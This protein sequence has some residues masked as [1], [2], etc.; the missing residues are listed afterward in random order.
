MCDDLDFIITKYLP[1]TIKMK[2]NVTILVYKMQTISNQNPNAL[3]K[4]INKYQAE[5]CKS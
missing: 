5:E 3:L 4:A 1:L 2:K